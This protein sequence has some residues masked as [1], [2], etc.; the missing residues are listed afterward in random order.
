MFP[1]ANAFTPFETDRSREILQTAGIWNI[2]EYVS[3]YIPVFRWNM[4]GIVLQFINNEDIWYVNL[5]S[6]VF[7]KSWL[8]VS[9][10]IT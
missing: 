5:I 9:R 1:H 7:P 10:A 4:I 3:S 6:W 8:L 2:R